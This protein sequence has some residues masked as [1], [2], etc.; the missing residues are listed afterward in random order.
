[1]TGGSVWWDRF[2][3]RNFTVGNVIPKRP[4]IPRT[5]Q[6]T[7][8]QVM[9]A[10][11]TGLAALNGLTSSVKLRLTPVGKDGWQVDDVYI[12]PWKVT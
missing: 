1:M 12:D 9:L 8:P 6:P 10:N 3:R 4:R 11:L 2:S 7:L 5:W